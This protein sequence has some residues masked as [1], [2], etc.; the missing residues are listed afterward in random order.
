MK[1]TAAFVTMNRSATAET[2]IER[3]VAQSRRPEEIIV[4]DNHSTDDTLV[5][6][7]QLKSRHP[8]LLRII[9]LDE[10]LGNAGGID[11]ALE[12]AF[13]SGSDFVWILDDDSWPRAGALEAMLKSPW[14]PQV[15]RHALQVD[16]ETRRLTWPMWTRSDEEWKLVFE[17]SELPDG[18][19]IP[20]LTSWT[21]ILVSQ[22][23]RELAGPVNGALFIRGEDEEYPWR[24]SQAGFSFE[25]V[26]GAVLDHPGSK[27]IVHWQ[28]FGKHFFYERGL[29][30]WKLHYKVRNMVWLKLRQ[31]GRL[32][33]V[34]MAL[35]Y[36]FAAA[37]LDSPGRLPLVLEACRDGLRG[38]LGKWSKHQ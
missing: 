36:L 6:L 16:P 17:V 33:A 1:L 20:S 22:K 23:V 4:I 8:T 7:Q 14:D 38:K 15:V 10:N 5:V 9:P 31:S 3:L 29:A 27:S 12:A 2:C 21:G 37:C 18:D 26:R 13:A 35:S 19:F 28:L 25:G 30:D 32:S 24:I 11:I 34:A